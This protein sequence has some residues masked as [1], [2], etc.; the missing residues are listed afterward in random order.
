[1]DKGGRSATLIHVGNAFVYCHSNTLNAAISS[2][3][4]SPMNLCF[5]CGP[6]SGV[7]RTDVISH[8]STAGT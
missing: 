4:L 7:R 1:M 2:V 3:G 8:V 5:V 6:A